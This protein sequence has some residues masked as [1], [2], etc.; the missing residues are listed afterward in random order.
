MDY[1]TK[2]LYTYNILYT[3]VKW[4]IPSVGKYRRFKQSVLFFCA[5]KFSLAEDY[6]LLLIVDTEKV[7]LGIKTV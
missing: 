4:L 5:I 7:R 2:K 6:S 3:E 1:T